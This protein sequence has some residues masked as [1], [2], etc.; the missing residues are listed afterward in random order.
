MAS[1]MLTVKEVESRRRKVGMHRVA[2]GLYLRVTSASSAYWMLR[3]SKSAGGEGGKVKTTE[4]SLGRYDDLTL[5]QAA[6]KAAELRSARREA[7]IDP[8]QTKHHKEEREV[9]IPT[10]EAVARDLIASKRAGWKSAKHAAQWSATLETYAYPVIGSRD[11]STI[12]TAAVLDVLNPL[13]TTKHETATRLRQRI[14]AVLT[15]AKVR[16]LRSGE[17]P[18]AW[19]GHLAALLP[20]ISKKSRVRHHPAMRWQDL[21]RFMAE[22]RRRDSMSARALELTILT[23]CRTSGVLGAI[24]GEFDLDAAIWTI[25]PERMKGGVK[26]RVALSDAAVAMLR[27][28]PRHDDADWVFWTLREGE[29]HCLSNMAM[30]ELLRGMHPGL[31]VHG[32][33]SSFRDWAGEATHHPRE[34]IEHALAHQI[35]DPAEAAY[36]RGDALERR[37]VLMRDWSDYCAGGGETSM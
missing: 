31:T 36:R 3:Y 1:G 9:G 33:R 28:L 14:E 7:G 8:L 17:N 11:V 22:L 26:H 27:A 12:D 32:F 23:A 13:W 16:G 19:R 10:F 4:M 29:P 25:P 2:P 5:A 6:A 30:L 37:R 35:M 20:T 18:A 24:W 15:A 34:I 21:P